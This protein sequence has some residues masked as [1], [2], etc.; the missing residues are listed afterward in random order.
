VYEVTEQYEATEC[1]KTG[2]YGGPS[3]F[4]SLCCEPLFCSFSI[5]RF[6]QGIEQN[7][8]GLILG[9]VSEVMWRASIKPLKF[10]AINLVP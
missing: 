4:E 5:E 8:R 1:H 2:D 10:H 3:F 9:T 7:L 6:L